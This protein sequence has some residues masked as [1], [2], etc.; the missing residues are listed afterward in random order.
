LV[1]AI[2]ALLR[3]CS[4]AGDADADLAE[5]GSDAFHGCIGIYTRLSTG[6]FGILYFGVLGGV[7]IALSGFFFITA[8]VLLVR[9]YY[10]YEV[11]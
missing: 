10:R 5:A 6:I 9:G 7:L 8:S 4:R 2:C 3:Y 1:Y 11:R